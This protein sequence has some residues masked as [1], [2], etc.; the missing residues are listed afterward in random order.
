M[1]TSEYKILDGTRKG[2]LRQKRTKAKTQRYLFWDTETSLIDAGEKGDEV[3][4]IAHSI[5]ASLSP[6]GKIKI[7]SNRHHSTLKEFQ[8]YILHLNKSLKNITMMAHNTSFDLQVTNFI[9]FMLD[10]GYK[11]KTYY[12]KGRTT[13]IKL[14]KDNLTITI[15]D[16]MNWF[17]TSLSEIGEGIGYE[18]G[19]VDF[20]N[21]SDSDLAK[22][23][24]RDVEILLY[25]FANYK[26]WLA[27]HFN[28]DMG[29]TR[30][31]DSM[32]I[33]RRN[34]AVMN[35]FYTNNTDVIRLEYEGYNGGRVECFKIGDFTDTKLTKLDINSLYPSV[36]ETGRFSTKLMR[37]EYEP[38]MLFLQHDIRQFG[39]VAK[40]IIKTDLPLFPKKTTAGLLFP[41]GEFETVL[42]GDELKKAMNR[43]LIQ[44]VKE[45]AVYHQEPIFQDHMKKLFEY[46]Q[47]A[48]ALGQ[49][50]NQ[51]NIKLLMNSLYGKF[52]QMNGDL[53]KK[54]DYP[55]KDFG[56]VQVMKEDGTGFTQCMVI[57]NEVFEQKKDTLT[58][59]TFPIIAAEITANARN[60]MC[61]IF[62]AA[63]WH[64]LY[65]TDTDSLITNDS[66][67]RLLEQYIDNK[68]LGYLKDEGKSK[69]C[70]IKGLKNYSWNG[71]RTLKGVPLSADY[72]GNNT[73]RFNKFRTLNQSIFS[74][75]TNRYSHIISK[76]V[77]KGDYSK[78]IVNSDK[79]V[80]PFR[81]STDQ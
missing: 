78:G 62:E 54:Y 69:N 21:V 27:D 34:D 1:I 26:Q 14:E 44:D 12:S 46:R 58:N 25:A 37:Y 31:N 35:L 52:G 41:V 67:V 60:K 71:K 17:T 18:K 74:R 64:N 10:E 23:C 56:Y 77:M 47:Q 80:S 48:K 59:H 9:P 13:V 53:V 43:G 72:I 6:D 33:F 40:V 81:L 2:Y 50:A 65:Y 15:L 38:D 20:E 16:S 28:M 32:N 57:N 22:Y 7:K 61:D 4:K 24:K 49:E 11:I 36:M 19:K 73:Y 75:E 39:V 66:G 79:T 3:F 70:I 42:C 5:L 76:K 51:M 30:G 8:D 55:I 45:Y 29:Y 63:R 68:K